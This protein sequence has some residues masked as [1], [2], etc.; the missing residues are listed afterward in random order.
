LRI[1]QIST[2]DVAGGAGRAAYR[3]HV[4][5]G[6]AGHES[7]MLVQ[8]KTLDDP[9]IRFFAPG[10]S[11]LSRRL[12]RWRHRRI[13]RRFHAYD[14]TRPSGYESFS[15]DCGEDG[16]RMI[17][18][19]LPADVLHLH[20]VGQFL[21]YGS[22]LHEAERAEIPL[23]WTFHDLNPMTGGCHYPDGCERWTTGCGRCPQLGS[24][25]ENDLSAW[26]WRRK[27]RIF[28]RLD[29]RRLHIITPSR[30]LGEEAAR[31]PLVA[32][33]S[34]S[35]IANGMDMAAFAPRSRAAVRESL[36]IPSDTRVVLFTANTL[37]I[38]RKGAALLLE[39]LRG[40]TG[41][42]GLLLLTIGGE[43]LPNAGN[44]PV[45][46]MGYLCDERLL[47]TVMTAADVFA[48]TSLEDNLP[49]TVLE[50]MG[51][52][53]PVVGFRVGGIPDM[54]RPDENGLL[55][56]KGDTA[57]L[58]EA[59]ARLLRED[60]LRARLSAGARRIAVREYDMAHQA[61][62]CVDLYERLLAE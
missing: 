10:S 43:S 46:H 9:G 35:V 32:R 45:R 16:R 48:I 22:F 5:L 17:A 20:W 47:A 53:L 11:F 12:R 1:V 4:G 55:V 52:G 50:A 41:V 8:R 38:R 30:W 25:D 3:L 19:A 33:F 51:C 14:A 31:S 29:C 26:I 58:Q 39:A 54:V 62:A 42:P 36:G 59:L 27:R 21:D 61:K 24:R 18:Q 2:W 34:R 56:E 49:N 40:L 57:A 37:S 7:G 44:L 28:E 15:S 6:R 60:D 13:A 23:V